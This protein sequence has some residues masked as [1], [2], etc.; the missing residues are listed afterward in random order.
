VPRHVAGAARTDPA[1]EEPGERHRP[2]ASTLAE[3]RTYADD[4]TAHATGSS[5][6][7][8]AAVAIMTR[9]TVEF[10]EDL[11]LRPSFKKSRRFATSSE[12]RRAIGEEDGPPVAHSFLDL[13][14]VQ[15][16]GMGTV[17]GAHAVREEAA[18]QSMKRVSGLP[19]TTRRKAS[20]LAMS[21]VPRAMYGAGPQPLAVT[22]LAALQRAAAAVLAPGSRRA[23]PELVL[24]LV[25]SWR[26]DPGAV[27]VVKPFH[28]LQEVL[29][30]GAFSMRE[31]AMLWALDGLSS[32]PL[33][34]CRQAL[35]LAGATL[36]PFHTLWVGGQA[37]QWAETPKAL[38]QD[39]LVQAYH[40]ARWA[41]LAARRP[42]Y[43]FIQQ[44]VDLAATRRYE[45]AKL[46]EAR[47]AAL[48]SV[49]VGG[50]FG[51][52]TAARWC[53]RG[54]LCPFCEEEPETLEHRFWRCPCWEG[55]RRQELGEWSVERLRAVLGDDVLV[56]GIMPTDVALVRAQAAYEATAA[57][58]APLSLA[59]KA[60]TDG[61]CLHPLDVPL[62]RAA[63]AVVQ[64]PQRQY[65]AVAAGAV[66][67]R[68]S[69][70]RAELCALVWLSRCQGEFTT[71]TDARYLY[72]LL[73]RYSPDTLP[74]AVLQGMNGDLWAL[75]LRAV[76]CEWV[77][78][79]CTRQEA[80]ARG[81]S[82][83]DWL[84]NAAADEVAKATAAAGLPEP[85]VVQKR[86]LALEA[87]AVVQAV[88]AAVQEAALHALRRSGGVQ[89]TRLQTRWQPQRKR[90]R[91]LPAALP[92]RVPLGL[93]PPT[94]MH[95]LRAPGAQEGGDAAGST[96]LEC[97]AC[98]QAARKLCQWEALARSPCT[99]GGGQTAGRMVAGVHDLVRGPAGWYC[100]RCHL[101]ASPA[102]RA[103]AARAKCPILACVDADPEHAGWV[104]A[105]GRH[106]L[107]QREVWRAAITGRPRPKTKRLQE[108]AASGPG[109]LGS[110][111]PPPVLEPAAGMR[112]R[113]HALARRRAGADAC[114]RCG[115]TATT[116]D[117]ARLQAT[118]CALAVRT[119]PAR[120]RAP[121]LGGAFD[122]YLATARPQVRD[123]AMSH[124]WVPA[125]GAAPAATPVCEGPAVKRMRRAAGAC[126]PQ[127]KAAPWPD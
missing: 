64:R 45:R 38:L 36:E 18:I 6:Q 114:L 121:L 122:E 111:P 3:V 47:R 19:W 44:G 53:S 105:W 20:C 1:P 72:L 73:C 97:T 37:L 118:P 101:V 52:S 57:W 42:R 108:E 24:T 123:L 30:H 96:R 56:T 110:G 117:A 93:K 11:H 58:P 9:H 7:V 94:G 86:Q 16:A 80:E 17:V 62:R 99:A 28:I 85:G 33:H 43:T 54:A 83:E 61:S 31:L 59:G 68:Q 51:Q 78:A 41:G 26:A 76:H 75:L 21:A 77:K 22:R 107:L 119:L 81:I 29:R 102:R 34:A 71:V 88:I 60:W 95:C 48:R 35:D 92:K 109:G 67:G 126:G 82:E 104:Y 120:V 125:D 98:G 74:A 65:I 55:R 106:Q 8:V 91:R 69:I 127:T 113:A 89:R 12:S 70:G 100:K 116:R 112:W 13:G 124:G 66:P 49:V 2:G 5:A 46:T 115:A 15:M 39:V 90:R 84:G 40:H 32:G 10:A 63:W 25:P 87:H 103:A 79:H 50:A 27:M 4:I 14:V 23:A